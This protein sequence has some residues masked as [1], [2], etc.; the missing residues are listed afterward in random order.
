MVRVLLITALLTGLGCVTSGGLVSRERNQRATFLLLNP[1]SG[2]CSGVV[3]TP[4]G[5]ILTA[6]HCLDRD[7][8]H[9]EV[10]VDSLAAPV[11]ARVIA[12]NEHRDLALLKADGYRWESSARLHAGRKLH[13][14]DTIYHVGHPFGGRSSLPQLFG[15]GHIMHP[16]AEFSELLGTRWI[17]IDLETGRPGASGS[18]AYDGQTGGL[19]GMVDAVATFNAPGFDAM[20]VVLLVPYWYIREFLWE[21]GVN[22]PTVDST[23]SWSAAQTADQVQFTSTGSPELQVRTRQRAANENEDE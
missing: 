10:H 9:L 15:V 4:D 14:G 11:E 22:V 2:Q 20:S 21:N 7:T 3:L 8:T 19:I 6:A 1:G 12:Y 17:F 16:N 5:Y 23:S 13:A 18:G